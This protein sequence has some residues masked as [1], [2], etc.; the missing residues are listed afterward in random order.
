MQESVSGSVI[1]SCSLKAL[2]EYVDVSDESRVYI[3]PATAIN[4][5]H[6]ATWYSQWF[7]AAAQCTRA[8]M[9]REKKRAI[10]GYFLEKSERTVQL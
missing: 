8:E 7:R 5:G 2:P 1:D 10:V 4:Q 6:N 9:L 3:I